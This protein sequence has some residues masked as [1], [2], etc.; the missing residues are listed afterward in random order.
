MI[1]PVVFSPDISVIR[2]RGVAVLEVKLEL[3]LV[4]LE[5]R[6][7]PEPRDL[8]LGERG[9]LLLAENDVAVPPHFGR[10]PAA[11][12]GAARKP[13]RFPAILPLV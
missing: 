6:R 1:H 10:G 11:T 3:V 5:P 8:V 12:E 9:V 2:L 7:P 13:R 4:L